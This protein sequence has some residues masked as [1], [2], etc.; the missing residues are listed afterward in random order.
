MLA[1]IRGNVC[2][3]KGYVYSQ[4]QV[5]DY[6]YSV[7]KLQCSW[8]NRIIMD[9]VSFSKLFRGRH[10]LLSILHGTET[11]PDIV[12]GAHMDSWAQD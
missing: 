2:I 11:T 1:L 3:L 4:K 9:S 10:K 6:T 5:R 12:R 7:L 8:C